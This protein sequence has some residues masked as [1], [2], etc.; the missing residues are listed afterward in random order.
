ML[1]AIIPVRKSNIV[2]TTEIR[3]LRPHSEVV[4]VRYILDVFGQCELIYYE[5]S[6]SDWI[7]Q[8]AC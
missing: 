8:D 3:S 2:L 6:T 7:A 4:T 1:H 5:L